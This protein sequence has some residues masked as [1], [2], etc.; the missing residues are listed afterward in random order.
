[1]ALFSRKNPDSTPEPETK[2]VPEAVPVRSEAPLPKLV[3]TPTLQSQNKISEPENIVSIIPFGHYSIALTKDRVQVFDE[4]GKEVEDFQPIGSST[5]EVN[6]GCVGQEYEKRELGI[7]GFDTTELAVSKLPPSLRSL[8]QEK[9]SGR[10]NR[11]MYFK[12]M[13][14]SQIKLENGLSV[15]EDGKYVLLTE[16]GSTFIAFIT[17][18]NGSKQ[19]P[20]NW[21]RI[22]SWQ[23]TAIPPDLQKHLDFVREGAESG[24]HLVDIGGKYVGRV[25]A[26]RLEVLDKG[27]AT[28]TV[29][30]TDTVHAIQQ[31]ICIDPDQPSLVYY[32]RSEK[33]TEILQLDTSSDA[34]SWHTEAAPLPKEYAH[35]QNLQLD[36][37]GKFFQFYSGNQLMFLERSTLKEIETEIDLTHTNFDPEGRIRAVD[38]E[39]RL[40]ICKTNLAAISQEVER[41]KI[42]QLAQGIQIDDLFAPEKANTQSA[43]RR[44]SEDVSHL[45]PL[46]SQ[47]E[48]TFTQKLQSTKGLDDVRVVAQALDGLRSRLK[49]QGL[50]QEHSRFITEGIERMITEKSQQFSEQA[51]GVLV[52][53][54]RSRLDGGVTL[55]QIG[56]VRKNLDEAR[57][58][59]NTVSPTVR[60][61]IATLV[62]EFERK[63]SDLFRTKGADIEKEIDGLIER[64]SRVLQGMETKGQF[65]EWCEFTLPQLKRSLA[66]H[67]NNCPVEC[68]Q[69][70]EKITSARRRLQELGDQYAKKFETQY[71][72][73]REGAA[74]RTEQMIATLHEE[75]NRLVERLQA[76]SFGSRTEAEQFIEQSPARQQLQAEID[77]LANRNEDAA[78]ELVRTLKVSIANYLY[79]I[80]RSGAVTT[81]R[82]GREMEMFGKTPFPKFEATVA[83][84]GDKDASIQF[85]AEERTKGAGVKPGEIMG[86]VGMLITTSRG[87]KETIRLWQNRDDEDEYRYG[88]VEY[89]GQ[90]IFPSYLSQEEYRKVKNFYR[91]WKQ[92]KLK[93]ELTAK[94]DALSKCYEERESP[95]ARTEQ[96]T[97]W[98][99]R[100]RTLFEDYATFCSTRYIP[101]LRRLEQIEQAEEPEYANGKGLVPEWQNHWVVA[102]EDERVLE[103]MAKRFKMQSELQEGIVNLKGHAG[104]GKDV[105]MKMFANRTRRPYFSIDCSKWTTEFELSEDIQL[106]AEDGA[107]QTVKVPSVVLSAI[108]TPGAIMYFNEI[109][110]MPEQAQIF[111]HALMDEKRSLTLKTSSGKVV[112]AHPSVLLASSMNPGYP[113]TFDPQMATRSRMISLEVGYPPIHREK[114]AGDTNPNPPYSVSEALKIA[115]SV[116]SLSDATMDPDMNRNDFVHWWDYQVNRI[117]EN[118]KLSAAQEFDINAI[119]AL[120]Q[121]AHTLRG[122]FIQ[123]F[124]KTRAS[125]DRNALP[126]KQPITLR[127][128]RRCGYFLSQMTPE[129]KVASNPERVAKDLIETFFL[130]HIDSGEERQKIKSAME[131][132][133]SQ[134]RISA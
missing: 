1:M 83:K 118:P 75:I 121:F 58:M 27:S 11:Y 116:D 51:I 77:V 107:S 106:E 48:A 79:E 132:W 16:D 2:P 128:M 4:R 89:K 92:G 71:E 25:N 119:L 6:W 65:D 66:E 46:K 5:T 94:R 104:T 78:K 60:V 130:S 31:N 76:R 12:D 133:T 70:F 53:K 36:P 103:E 86:D 29:L 124:E 13:S 99:E 59:S 10:A 39:G 90:P 35:V 120:M 80:E 127:E 129:E 41:R 49:T 20:R 126:V 23:G 42:A 91:D 37:S 22:E 111:L 88:S 102:P 117:G 73:I 98:Q 105:Y 115:R 122:H 123:Q 63:S 55:F 26:D 7:D 43:A 125:R 50:S 40:V 62:E 109:N 81:A 134:R 96:D 28:G 87:K 114:D 21:Q 131:T 100:Y 112:K 52:Q 108:Q 82:D 57:S 45:A 110:A 14:S 95:K 3:L 113:G 38:R 97:Q 17:E 72:A 9:L 30:F 56:E 64:E 47:Y 44:P 84:K 34:A 54:V 15:I 101:F 19:S 8:G 24:S 18:K 69:T 32:C 67:A 74:N 93:Q 85:F 33:P 68:Q 61:E